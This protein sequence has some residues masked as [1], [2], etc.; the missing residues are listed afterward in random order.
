M[1][2]QK[3]CLLYPQ[4]HQNRQDIGLAASFCGIAIGRGD[5]FQLPLAC[6]PSNTEYRRA[7]VDYAAMQAGLS[8]LVAYSVGIQGNHETRP[9]MERLYDYIEEASLSAGGSAHN[10]GY[11]VRQPSSGTC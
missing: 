1:Q 5:F 7:G 11:S 4:L 2:G 3:F 9:Y 10:L 6:C 8:K